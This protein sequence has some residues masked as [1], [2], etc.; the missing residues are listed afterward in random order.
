MAKKSEKPE[1]S[2]ASVQAADQQSKSRMNGWAIAGISAAGALLLA[3]SAAAGAIV[4]VNVA[5]SEPRGGEQHA[6]YMDDHDGD[7]DHE[8]SDARGPEDRDHGDRER[9]G[10]RDGNGPQRPQGPGMPGQQDAPTQPPAP[11]TQ[12]N[13]TQ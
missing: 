6:E 11:D 7:R 1:K 3:G 12:G 8:Q 9:H 4:G 5:D 10:D 2:E 13:V